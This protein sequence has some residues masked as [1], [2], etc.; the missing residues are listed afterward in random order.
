ML[1][2]PG[3]NVDKTTN[4]LCKTSLC[5]LAIWILMR[6]SCFIQEISMTISKNESDAALDLSIISMMEVGTGLDNTET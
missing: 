3:I 5:R 4:T 1:L 6:S 2:I